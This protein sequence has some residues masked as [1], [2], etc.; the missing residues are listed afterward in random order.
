[1]YKVLENKTLCIGRYMHI[2]DMFAYSSID[3]C[4]F[5]LVEHEYYSEFPSCGGH[6]ACT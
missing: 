5:T 2:N 3:E 6:I 1:V 4:S